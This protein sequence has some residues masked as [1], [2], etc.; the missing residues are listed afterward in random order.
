MTQAEILTIGTELLLGEIVDT[1]TQTIARELRAIGLDLFRTGVVGD[2]VER[3]A[4]AVREASDR[5]EVV[6]TAG[7]LGP[8]VD[9]YTRE[10]IA[11]AFGLGLE[12]HPELWE[13]IRERFARFGL[14]PPENNRRQAMLPTGARAI[15]NPVGTA[16]AFRVERGDRVVIALPG[17][18]AELKYLL[19]AAVV[20]YLRDSRGLTGVIKSRLIRTAGVG[21]SWLDERIGDLERLTNPTVGLAAH[22]GRVDIRIAVKAAN[23]AAAD[24]LLLDV[25]ITLRERLTDRIY[26]VDTET[27]EAAAIQA[28]AQ[29]GWK[30][31]VVEAGTGGALTAALAGMADEAFG[32][33]EVLS[34][35]GSA[36]AE[37]E[38][39][40]QLQVSTGAQ[41]GLLLL[42][43]QTGEQHEIDLALRWPGGSR[44]WQRMYGGAPANAPA[45][46]ASLALDYLRRHLVVERP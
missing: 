25:E 1:N 11:L 2:N 20:P 18:P 35:A 3:I 32:G 27:L 22:P 13:Q 23:E 12:F 45:W 39:L 6:I 9:D 30:L 36:Q 28:V 46:A 44:D 42:L 15:E 33:G 43:R 34:E 40:D 29:A 17:V 8:T 10:A 24:E 21:E 26:G 38:A 16:P 7:G 31:A 19:Q 4:Q 37:R 14:E 5:A 41:V